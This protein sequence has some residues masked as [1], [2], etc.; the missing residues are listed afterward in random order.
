MRY[1]DEHCTICRNTPLDFSSVSISIDLHMRI[2]YDVRSHPRKL[3]SLIN[4]HKKN[5]GMRCSSRLAQGPGA[6]CVNI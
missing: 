2:V 4:T 6:I 5:N 1:F 3:L